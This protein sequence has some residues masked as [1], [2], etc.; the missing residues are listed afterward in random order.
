MEG[1]SKGVLAALGALGDALEISE[2][3]PPPRVVAVQEAHVR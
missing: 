2:A 3:L 1:A